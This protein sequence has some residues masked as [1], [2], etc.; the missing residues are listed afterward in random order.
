MAGF[1]FGVPVPA[2]WLSC[3]RGQARE[4]AST[5]N[6]PASAMSNP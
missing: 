5:G 6:Q 4:R 3:G 2:Q 1:V